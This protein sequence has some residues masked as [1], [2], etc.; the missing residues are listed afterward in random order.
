MGLEKVRLSSWEADNSQVI[1]DDSQVIV[2]LG[3]WM[4][5]KRL[6]G[7]RAL[8]R[9]GRA[10]GLC[11]PAIAAKRMLGLRA[12]SRGGAAEPRQEE[13][14]ARSLLELWASVWLKRKPWWTA[15][16]RPNLCR[17]LHLRNPGHGFGLPTAWCC[18]LVPFGSWFLSERKE[19]ES[20]EVR[21]WA[22]AFA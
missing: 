16:L 21:P 8:G 5:A 1:V 12:L 14:V 15:V 13:E 2:E 7:L 4:P 3:N 11:K 17:A 9:K 10:V 20:S 19:E 6:L 22:Y 18:C